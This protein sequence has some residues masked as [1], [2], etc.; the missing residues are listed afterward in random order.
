MKFTHGLLGI[1]YPSTSWGTMF[2]LI[3]WGGSLNV[4]LQLLFSRNAISLVLEGL[5]SPAGG[6]TGSIL[7]TYIISPLLW[8]SVNRMIP[9]T[10]RTGRIAHLRDK[11]DRR[12]VAI[13]LLA[14][15]APLLARKHTKS[16]IC[17]CNC[18]SS[19]GGPNSFS[20]AL[21]SRYLR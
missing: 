19:G 1:P 3:F 21:I 7:Q 2:C 17:L 15:P 16:Q 6:N 4:D 5:I 12:S 18:D 9:S 13:Y 20:V 10:V 11:G 14:P 8:S